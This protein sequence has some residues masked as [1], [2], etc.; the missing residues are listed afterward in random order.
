MGSLTNSNMH[1]TSAIEND[2][3]DFTNDENVR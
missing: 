2:E 1:E 3:Y